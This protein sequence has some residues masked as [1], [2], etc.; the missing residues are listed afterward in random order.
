MIEQELRARDQELRAIG[1]FFHA[2]KDIMRL[3]ILYALAAEEEMTVTELAQALGI[4]QPLVSFHLHPL[5]QL[6]LVNVRRWGREVFCSLNAAE[7][8]AR[9]SGFAELLSGASDCTR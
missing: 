4:S 7:I 2:L 6:G 9:Q 5:R 3:R 1:R 8:L